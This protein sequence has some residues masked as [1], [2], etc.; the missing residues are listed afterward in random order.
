[1]QEVAR[2]EEVCTVCNSNEDNNSVLYWH[3]KDAQPLCDYCYRDKLYH[4]SAYALKYARP[5]TSAVAKYLVAF[6]PEQHM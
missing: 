6:R 3:Y 5:G 1:M 2:C 4:Y